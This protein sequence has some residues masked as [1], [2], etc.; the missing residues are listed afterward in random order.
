[1]TPPPP[2]LTTLP[3]KASLSAPLRSGG[4]ARPMEGPSHER[5]R[6][7]AFLGFNE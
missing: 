7:I 4:A 5:P 1:M 2:S 6:W 3:R